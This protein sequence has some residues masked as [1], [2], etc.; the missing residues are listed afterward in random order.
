MTF[1]KAMKIIKRDGSEAKFDI[2]K[3]I[4]AGPRLTSR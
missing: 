2:Q 4:V 1:T 3:I